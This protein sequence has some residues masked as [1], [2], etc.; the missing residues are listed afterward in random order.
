MLH[1]QLHAHINPLSIY[2]SQCARWEGLLDR[3]SA[4]LHGDKQPCTLTAVVWQRQLAEP[5]W[6]LAVGG[7]R[8]NWEKKT[9]HRQ[10]GDHANPPRKDSQPGNQTPDPLTGR[11]QWAA[12]SPTYTHTCMNTYI[13]TQH[14]QM[15]ALYVCNVT[16][17]LNCSFFCIHAGKYIIDARL[18]IQMYA[19][20]PGLHHL[21]TGDTQRT[22][23][24][25]HAS[26]WD[27]IAIYQF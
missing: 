4:R 20:A 22:H 19:G 9:P 15:H 14:I 8:N 16:S 26:V 25:V 12:L 13:H 7:S 17:R 11:Y 21:F 18:D 10:G 24:S 23:A 5:A 3:V 1:I 6:L 2:F 27:Q